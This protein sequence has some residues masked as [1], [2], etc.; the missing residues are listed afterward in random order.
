MDEL[1]VGVCAEGT[2]VSVYTLSEEVTMIGSDG[3]DITLIENCIR[4]TGCPLQQRE[5]NRH[6]KIVHC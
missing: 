4:L 1:H 6:V 3:I 5:G 2:P